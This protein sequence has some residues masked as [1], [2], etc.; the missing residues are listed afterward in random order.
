MASI[1][2]YGYAKIKETIE[3][4]T[5][6]DKSGRKRYAFIVGNSDFKYYKKLPS[7]DTDARIMSDVLKQCGF[8]VMCETNVSTAQIYYSH[9]SNFRQQLSNGDTALVYFTGHGYMYD[10]IQFF[11]PTQQ[12]D[13]RNG[14]IDTWKIRKQLMEVVGTGFKFIIGD[15]CSN[16]MN[17]QVPKGISN[18]GFSNTI[19]SPFQRRRMLFD[20]MDTTVD[21]NPTTKGNESEFERLQMSLNTVNTVIM[22]STAAHTSA[23]GRPNGGQ[24]TQVLLQS[25]CKGLELQETI[26]H[27][28]KKMVTL[29]ENGHYEPQFPYTE[30]CVVD[31]F[32]FTKS[33]NIPLREIM[34]K[35]VFSR[36]NATELTS[37][38]SAAYMKWEKEIDVKTEVYLYGK[39]LTDEDALAIGELLKTNN[40][41]TK[42]GLNNNNITDVQS[43][44]EALNTNNTLTEL[45]LE[46]NNITG[47]QS[48]GELLKTNNALTYLSLDDNNITD[49]QSIGEGLKTNNT[50]TTL[51]LRNNNITD[52]SGIQS[53]IDGLKTNNTLNY[54]DLQ[55]NQLSYNMKSQLKAIQQYKRDGSNGY[56][57]VEGMTIWT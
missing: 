17:Q 12:H 41:V 35:N 47:V 9:L 5:L 42:L 25:L 52:D 21:S 51:N 23:W 44:G 49:V 57:K 27:F 20:V 8:H 48:I 10:G 45:Y 30:Q 6:A 50:L 31:E 38:K 33:N 55:Y 1:I 53:I 43:I 26:R 28:T 18:S 54:L 4:L 11:C 19:D 56:Q 3:Y 7:C 46:N 22:N 32:Y 2:N 13:S 36:F 15:C 16:R 34:E 14:G 40:T 29:V 24:F 39:N 37:K